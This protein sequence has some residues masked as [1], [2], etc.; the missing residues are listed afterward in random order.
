MLEEQG[1]VGPRTH[2]WNPQQQGGVPYSGPQGFGPPQGQAPPG[3]YGQGGGVNEFKEQFDKFA[4]SK[5]HTTSL[6]V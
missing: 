2:S 4:E 1:P 3:T 6:I 5:H